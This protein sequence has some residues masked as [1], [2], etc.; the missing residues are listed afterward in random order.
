[1]F[2]A[3]VFEKVQALVNTH[4][5]W[6][7]PAPEHW[8]GRLAHVRRWLEQETVIYRA[9]ATALIARIDPILASLQQRLPEHE[10]G[11]LL[12]R[13]DDRHV[14]KTPDSI[15]EKMA[16]RWEDP[17]RPPPISFNNLDE[18]NDLGRFRIVT[19]F[20][21]DVDWLCRHLEEPYDAT[22]RERLSPLQQ[23]LCREFSLQGNRFED[24]IAISPRKRMSGE[25]CRKA[26]FTSR[27]PEH[28]AY[29]VEVQLL[30]VLQE[31]WDKKDHFLIYERRRAGLRVDEA[32]E[33]LSFS[34]SEQLY[35]ADLMFDQLKKDTH[36][37]PSK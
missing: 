17:S 33:R 24:L 4:F 12:Y 34:L 6:E 31:S 29:R 15:L 22:K 5:S 20:L 26:H 3:P 13:L 7:E 36:H 18:L 35:L 32:H 14:L 23:T 2:P 21:S 37:A 16:R 30:T 1:M 10:R 27:A 28:R 11:R 8:E 25:R 19:N 9:V